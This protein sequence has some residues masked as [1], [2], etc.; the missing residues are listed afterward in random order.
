MEKSLMTDEQMAKLLVDMVF[1]AQTLSRD[2]F[3]KR[4]SGDV[5]SYTG[6]KLAAMKASLLDLKVSAHQEMLDREVDMMQA[7]ANAYAKFK[8]EHGA[9]AAG[10]MKYL[11]EDFSE[12]IKKYNHAKVQYE[13]FRSIVA[14]VH[15]LIDIIKSRVI[16][17][18]GARRDERLQ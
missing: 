13:R 9:T 18:Q 1:I 6:V 12:A 10:D 4:Q 11:D 16:D 8:K 5:L 7:K 3:I 17:L 2:D 14:D 15:D